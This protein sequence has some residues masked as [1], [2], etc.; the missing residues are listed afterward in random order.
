MNISKTTPNNRLPRMGNWEEKSPCIIPLTFYL[1]CFHICLIAIGFCISTFSPV[2][3]LSTNIIEPNQCSQQPLESLT[4]NL[5]RDLSNYANRASQRSR[6]SARRKDVFSYVLLAGK[7]EFI[8]LPLQRRS[9]TNMSEQKIFPGVEQVFFTT[10][11]RHYIGSKAVKL[12]EFHWLFLTKADSGWYRVMMFS[13]ISSSQ[14]KKQSTPLRES[15]GGHIG[16]A[17]DKWLRD[18]RA[19]RSLSIS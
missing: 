10:L 18:C 9:S 3:S 13:Q 12:Q 14:T 11:E 6:S 17:V 19:G 2:L 16:Q 7:P 15:S 8:P 4:T 5:L 1:N